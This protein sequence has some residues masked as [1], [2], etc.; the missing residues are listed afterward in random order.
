MLACSMVFKLQR[1]LIDIPSCDLAYKSFSDAF[2]SALATISASAA[3][4]F[5]SFEI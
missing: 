2:Y 3:L 1:R 5:I 4:Y